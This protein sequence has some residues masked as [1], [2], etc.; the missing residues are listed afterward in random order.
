MSQKATEIIPL[1]HIVVV[2][3][4]LVLIVS[5]SLLLWIMQMAYHTCL[6]YKL[7]VMKLHPQNS[8]MPTMIEHQPQKKK[9]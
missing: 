2:H 9:S 5:G 4:Q 8:D 6:F 1:F 3:N 7:C